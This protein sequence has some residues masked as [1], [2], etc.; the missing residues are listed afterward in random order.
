MHLARRRGGW[1]GAFQR[2]APHHSI[3]TPHLSTSLRSSSDYST[4]GF[5][6]FER[7][8][9]KREEIN[10][11]GEA[12]RPNGITKNLALDLLNDLIR[13]NDAMMDRIDP[14]RYPAWSPILFKLLE[15]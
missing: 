6:E 15:S 10:N 7:L 11:G 3:S 4:D 5:S 14:Y 1:L 8:I 13:M 9:A 12:E 2:R